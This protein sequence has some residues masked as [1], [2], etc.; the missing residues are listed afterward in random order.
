MKFT[1]LDLLTLLISL[2]LFTSCNNSKTIGLDVDPE[3]EIQGVLVDSLTV[4]TK[5]VAED[6]ATT[7]SQVIASNPLRYPLGF[8]TDPVIGTS[9]AS[10]SMGVSIPSAAFSF[11]SNPVLDSAVLVLPFSSGFYGD[12]T[13]SV[14]SV[15]VHQLRTDISQANSFKSNQ[16][17][18]FN[19][20][21]IGNFTGKIKPNT[22]LR[23]TDVVSGAADSLRTTTTGQMRI[24]MSKEFIQSRLL[25]LDTNSLK[26]NPTFAGIF[27]GLHVNIN[28]TTSTGTGGLM[29]FDFSGVN[30]RLEVYYKRNNATTAVNIDTVNSNFPVTFTAI[31]PVA[32]TVKHTYTT[33]VATQL[34]DASNTQYEVTYLQGTTGLRNKISFPYLKTFYE[35]FGVK[36]GAKIIINKAELVIDVSTGTDVAPFTAAPRLALYRNNIAGQRINLTD[37]LSAGTGFGGAY[38]LTTKKYTFVVT[39]YLQELLDGKTEDYG[40]YLG[41]LPVGESFITPLITTGSRSIIGSFP[42][43]TNKTRLNV[44]YTVVN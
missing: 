42:N 9:E 31:N 20:D 19:T 29:F 26:N 36:A 32:A 6:P 8:L 24:K 27:K 40:T 43:A 39:N 37:F 1:K 33:A 35:K 11:G 41:V 22:T 3:T 23:V 28:K 17:F 38:D 14:Y 25:V 15:D 44:Y 21:L 16:E 5:T 2:F 18:A 13:T 12:T 10:L 7:W 4:R 34:A 30:S